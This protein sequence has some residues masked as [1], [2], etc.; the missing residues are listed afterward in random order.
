MP[1]LKLPDRIYELTLRMN[2]RGYQMLLKTYVEQ[3]KDTN[4]KK[5]QMKI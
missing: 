4:A 5:I 1:G 2:G 3:N